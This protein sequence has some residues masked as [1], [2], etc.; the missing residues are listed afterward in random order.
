MAGKVLSS[1]PLQMFIYFHGWYSIFFFFVN[2]LLFIYKGVGMPYPA[3]NLG[4][5]ITFIFIYAVVQWI[6]LFLGSKGNKTEQSS[7][8]A[9]FLGLSVPL[10]LIHAFYMRLQIYVL[11]ADTI[12]NV[13]SFI[14]LAAEVFLGIITLI[15][16]NAHEKLL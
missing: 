13:A 4:W 7:S 3:N 16:F 11:R 9:W 2:I 5:E 6:R 12:I 8:L 15:V 10:I 14:F 1:L